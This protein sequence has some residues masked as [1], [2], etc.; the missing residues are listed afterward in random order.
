MYVQT[1]LA[2]SYDELG[3]LDVPVG[4]GAAMATKRVKHNDMSKQSEQLQQSCRP[5]P[6]RRKCS[7]ADEG[8]LPKAGSQASSERLLWMEGFLL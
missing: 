8:S 7:E 1:N 6:K 5:Q 3:D 4:K 2:E